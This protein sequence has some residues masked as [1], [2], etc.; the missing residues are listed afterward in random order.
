MQTEFV[1]NKAEV[2]SEFF[3]GLKSDEPKALV[4][5]ANLYI[6]LVRTKR[7]TQQECIDRLRVLEDKLAAKGDTLYNYFRP[8]TKDD[9]PQNDQKTA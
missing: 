6:E 3:D 8:R 4:K 7:M 2:D 5:L 1:A 9:P